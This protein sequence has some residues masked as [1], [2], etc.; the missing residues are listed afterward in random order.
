[1]K[2]IIAIVGPPNV[3]KSTLFNRLAKKR[4][5]IVADEPGTTIDRN[6]AEVT[7][8]GRPLTMVD[9]GGFEPNP[10]RD[11]M[12]QMKEQTLLAIEEADAVIHLSDGRTG[13]TPADREMA[14][15]LRKTKKP[16]FFAVNKIDAP[17]HASLTA[18]FYELGVAPIYPIS[19]LHGYGIYEL[20]EDVVASL[21]K[22]TIAN[23]EQDEDEIRLAVIG[24]PNVGKSSLVNR[25]L[26]QNRTV[27][28]PQPGTTRDA[29]DTPFTYG[30]RHYLLIDTAGIRKKSR[31]SLTLEK[32]SVLSALKTIDRCDIAL[33]VVDATEGITEQDVK[34]AGLAYEEGK[35]CLFVVNKWDAIEKNNETVGYY[36]KAIRDKAKFLDFAPIIFVSA[37]SGQ[38]VMKIFPLIEDVYVQYTKRIPTAEVN[39]VC[40]SI[41]DENPPPRVHAR[42][43]SFTFM[44]QVSTRPPTFVFFVR[45]PEAIHFS[46]ERFLRNRL[47]EA[48]GFFY[49]PIRLIFRKKSRK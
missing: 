23:E 32:Y 1:V 31:I 16:V 47:R 15:L 41:I 9:T 12:A 26:G 39:R 40:R 3:G 33:I 29:I 17:K 14:A 20:M 18:E 37:L 7:W 4:R 30:G 45:E 46:Y 34:I 11:L 42:E 28:N 49:V 35:A 5:A 24:R 8:E 48:F 10:E 13:L 43:N 36:V 2:P 22:S 19:A 6:Y 44:T 25:I 21:P 38:R 27:V